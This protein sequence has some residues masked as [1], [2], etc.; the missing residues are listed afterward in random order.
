MFTTVAI[1]ILR[2]HKLSLQNALNRVFAALGA[3]FCV[4]TASAYSQARQKLKPELFIELN[5]SV[6][7]DFYQL[8]E[9]DGAVK[10]WR[11]HRLVA[12]DGT[13]LTLPDTV[14][15]RAEFSVQENQYEEGA[16]VQ[17][18]AV[19]I[20]DLLNDVAL[21]AALGK[22]QGEKKL[23]FAHLWQATNINDLL[24]FDRHYADYTIFAMAFAH[25]RHALVRLPS[26]SFMEAQ[27]FWRSELPEKKVRLK[28]PAKAR[29]FAQENNLPLE[30]DLRLIRVILDN[31]EIEVLATTLIDEQKYPLAEFKQLYGWRWGEET[32]FGR[33]KNI[34]EIERFS[35]T[36]PTAIK[37]DFYGVLFLATLESI[38]TKSAEVQL[39]Q[40][41]VER[42]NQLVPHV[43]HSVSYL[44][45]VD[46]VVVLLASKR[47]EKEVL[48]E[49]HHLF[50]QNPTRARPNRKVERNKGLRYA[51]K[52]RFHKYVKRL[53]A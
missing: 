36:T 53:L 46:H 8:Y 26:N 37:Q 10:R 16:C 47:S 1:L 4:P 12:G 45:L 14:D 34:F 13:Y 9:E 28:C 39:Q 48:E 23:L 43:N 50:S 52:L 5:E 18:L 7:D 6:R 19:V 27:N 42:G 40:Q 15:T 25:Q 33:I 35:G 17:A 24:I 2:G 38:L 30:I 21:A 11:G 49:L 51:Y 44:A 22:R 3:V 20:Y 29:K 31:G 41:A 32:F